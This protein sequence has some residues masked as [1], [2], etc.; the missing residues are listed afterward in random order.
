MPMKLRN[1]DSKR[2][3]TSAKDANRRKLIKL[4]GVK[5][6]KMLKQLVMKLIA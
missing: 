2:K 5:L 3:K 4:P 1:L 6:K